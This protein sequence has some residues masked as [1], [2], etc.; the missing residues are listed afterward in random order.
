MNKTYL[1]LIVGIAVALCSF[2]ANAVDFTTETLYSYQRATHSSVVGAEV[3]AS[4]DLKKDFLGQTS[5]SYSQAYGRDVTRDANLGISS[6]ALR[7]NV[8]KLTVWGFKPYVAAETSLVYGEK[9]NVNW[10]FSPVV[11]E[12]FSYKNWQLFASVGYDFS[13]LNRGDAVT[14]RFG[15]NLKF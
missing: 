14:A 15:V 11:G 7:Q 4:Q 9:R 3:S 6:L 13:A 5:V 10:S 12:S 1:S 2:S 8:D